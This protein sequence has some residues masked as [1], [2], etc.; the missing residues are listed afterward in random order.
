MKARQG[1]WRW[2]VVCGS[3]LTLTASAQER[4]R[5][6]GPEGSEY[7][8]GGYEARREGRFSLGLDF[9]A[10]M[11]SNPVANR[12][13]P[14]IFAGLTVSFWGDDWFVVDASGAYLLDSQRIDILV[15]PRFRTAFYPV[16]A[17]IGLKAGTVIS[18][19]S[20]LRFAISPQIG[21][22]LLLADKLIMGLNYNVDVPIWADAVAHR[23]YM[24]MGYRF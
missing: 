8:K 17:H 1:L 18:P 12:V 10:S 2:A 13:G 3:L 19:T 15:G 24:T 11:I 7:G 23:V 22:E 14:P 16:S 6:D 5:T 4:G 21:G 20:G 9:G